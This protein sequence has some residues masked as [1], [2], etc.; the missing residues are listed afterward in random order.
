MSDAPTPVTSSSRH[1]TGRPSSPGVSRRSP[2]RRRLGRSR[3][4]SSTTAAR[5]RS[6]RS[7]TVPRLDRSIL[8]RRS[9]EGRGRA[10]F[11]VARARG[12]YI[13]FTDDDCTFDEAAIVAFVD[14]L[15]TAPGAIVGGRTINALPGNPFAAASQAIVDAVY[16][17]NYP[18][19]AD[20]HFLAS[21]TWPASE[22]DSARGGFDEQFT[23]AA[24]DREPCDGGAIVAAGGLPARGRHLP[25]RRPSAGELRTPAS[26]LWSRR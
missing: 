22:R 3:S 14:A 21:T 20:A 2:R 7:S 24:E 10:E 4:W 15:A 1:T 13:V 11:G 18:D 25:R 8:V 19:P 12:K 23:G 16:A 5:C 9:Q 26:R 17:H 6:S